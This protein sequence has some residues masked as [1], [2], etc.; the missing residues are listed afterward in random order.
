DGAPSRPRVTGTATVTG[1]ADGALAAGAGTLAFDGTLGRAWSGRATLMASDAH[2][3]F[4][5]ADSAYAEAQLSPTRIDVQR[6]YAERAEST[7][8]AAGS[9]QKS[10]GGWDIRLD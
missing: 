1:F 10:G 5:H 2:A 6:F 9:A 3:G 8:T 4:A 7:L